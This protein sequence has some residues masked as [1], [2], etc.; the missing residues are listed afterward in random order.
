MIVGLHSSIPSA[1]SPGQMPEAQ[2]KILETLFKSNKEILVSKNNAIKCIDKYA[3]ISSG[4]V[5]ITPLPGIDLIG[6]AAVN[7][8]M[9]ME[10]SKKIL[11]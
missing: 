5:A 4:V 9:V 7:G 2:K 8:Q 1:F 11:Y 10:I 3:W 6:A